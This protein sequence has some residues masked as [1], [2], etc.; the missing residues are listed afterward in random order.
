[1]EKNNLKVNDFNMEK[2]IKKV[3][4]NYAKEIK[5]SNGILE[6]EDSNDLDSLALEKNNQELERLIEIK[7]IRSGDRINYFMVD[8]ENRLRE[9]S[10]Q[11][12][13]TKLIMG[14][15][16][17]G[18]S[19]DGKLFLDLTK[20]I[21]ILEINNLFITKFDINDFCQ[22]ELEGFGGFLINIFRNPRKFIFDLSK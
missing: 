15:S 22:E 5:T 21:N 17:Y 12:P 14:L 13:S 4:D 19:S 3:Q 8:N 20:A 1:M 16:E 11:L 10:F 6:L 2:E 9:I 7:K 18:I